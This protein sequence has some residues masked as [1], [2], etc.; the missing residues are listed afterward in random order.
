[1][2]SELSGRRNFQTSEK[3]MKGPRNS[4]YDRC[5]QETAKTPGWMQMSKRRGEENEVRVLEGQ[6]LSGLVAPCKNLAFSLSEMKTI[7]R[8]WAEPQHDL[9]VQENV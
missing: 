1:M 9:P 8:I 2:R 6:I 7:D 3:P 5:S 4:E